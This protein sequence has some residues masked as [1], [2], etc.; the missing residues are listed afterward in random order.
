[1]KFF[2]DVDFRL[3]DPLPNDANNPIT[4]Q[5]LEIVNLRS[6]LAQFEARPVGFIQGYITGWVNAVSLS[7]D[8]LVPAH[9]LFAGLAQS[10]SSE[11]GLMPLY[12]QVCHGIADR[13]QTIIS[14]VIS[15]KVK[16][17]FFKLTD[18]DD[19]DT[20]KT[21]DQRSDLL[22][23][24][25]DAHRTVMAVPGADLFVSLTT[26]KSRVKGMGVQNTAIVLPDNKAW[27]TPPQVLFFYVLPKQ[28]ELHG[29]IKVETVS[30][31]VSLALPDLCNQ[32]CAA[33]LVQPALWSQPC[34]ASLV[35]PAL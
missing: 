32:H 11:K 27:W 25:V 35:E 22:T 20:G 33:S 19:K 8:G 12:L 3:Q 15:H 26:D 10:A 14:L 2:A 23:Q 34:A 31:Q 7:Y 30:C 29:F 1:L 13:V 18:L 5:W 24:Y 17:P 4:L 6:V 9:D 28:C 21:K 16:K